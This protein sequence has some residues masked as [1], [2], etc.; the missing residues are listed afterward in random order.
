MTATPSPAP[1]SRVGPR[2]WGLLGFLSVL[3]GGSFFFA[4]VAVAEL[5]PLTLVLARVGL[6][7][8]ALHLIVPLTGRRMPLTAQPW[9]AFAV[10]GLLNNLVPFGLIF[11]GQTRIASGVASIL[12]A[13][14]PLFTVVVAHLLTHD[15]K[16]TGGRLLGILFGIAG[17]ASMIGPDAV[18]S[19]GGGVWGEVAVL[20][21]ALSYAFAGVWGCRFRALGLAPLVSACGQLSASTVLVLPLALLLDRPWALTAPHATTWAAV[22]GLALA[23]T[24]LAY[25]IFFRVLA[26][27]GATGIALVTFLI[28]VSAILLGSVFLGERLGVRHFAGMGLIALGL[29]AIDGRL[30]RPLRSLGMHRASGLPMPL[31]ESSGNQ[32]TQV[33]AGK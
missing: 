27:A 4:K 23:S 30:S 33:R 24:A 22:A 26:A 12:N 25:V 9:A 15:E 31:V 16:I 21:A 13:T 8:V 32:P 3:W 10:M 17:V 14:T 2:E 11:W 18:R 6:A 29:A 20:G 28:P 5:P 7:A 19:L 1:P